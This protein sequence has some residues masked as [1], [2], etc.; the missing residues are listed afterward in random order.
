MTED[1]LLLNEIKNKIS[2]LERLN[3]IIIRF[4]KT[5][6]MF[7]ILE[8]VVLA[9][10]QIL[11]RFVIKKPISWSE[12]LLTYSFIWVSFLGA[13]FALAKNKHFEVDLFTSKLSPNIRGIIFIFI[14]I[15]MII[16]TILMM[17]DGYEFASINRF[18]TMS[19]M[20]FTMFWPCMVVPLSGFFMFIH[21]LT[22]LHSNIKQGGE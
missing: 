14:K 15:L 9:A 1:V 2:L 21:L 17:K 7:L 20:P 8:M 12:E 22:D 18:Q 3:S 16:F 4:E 5:V 10:L 11:S 19:V 13:A 6:L